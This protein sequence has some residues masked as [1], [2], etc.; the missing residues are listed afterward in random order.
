MEIWQ[1]YVFFISVKI[2]YFINQL[3]MNAS[4]DEHVGE[5]KATGTNPSWAETSETYERQLGV[6]PATVY[7]L[8]VL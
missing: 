1:K 8:L 4:Y 3:N 2:L 7:I 6:H 5:L